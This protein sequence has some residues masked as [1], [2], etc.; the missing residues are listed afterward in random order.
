VDNRKLLKPDLKTVK[1]PGFFVV[2]GKLESIV[3]EKFLDG[4]SFG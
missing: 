1:M 4:N 2:G 3:R